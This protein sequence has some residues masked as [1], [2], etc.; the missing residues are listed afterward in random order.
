[1]AQTTLRTHRPGRVRCKSPWTCATTAANA[2]TTTESMTRSITL[3]V[4]GG[5]GIGPEVITEALKVLDVVAAAH[6][7]RFERTNYELGARRWHA[8]GEVLPDAVLAEISE[9]DAILLGA[10]GGRPNDTSMP[11][12]LLERGLL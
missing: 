3:A 7:L 4:I 5:D 10:V 12:G 1:M 6:D 11:P 9:H 2:R 8:T